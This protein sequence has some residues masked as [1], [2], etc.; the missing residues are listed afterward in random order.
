MESCRIGCGSGFWGDSAEGARQLVRAGCDFLVF[1]YLAE[2][3]MA[4]LA[5]NRRRDSTTGFVPD[6]ID[7]VFVPHARAIADQNIRVVAN[8]GGM[9]VEACRE[10]LQKVLQSQGVALKIATVSG[11]DLMPQ[12]SALARGGMALPEKLLSFNA[13]LGAAEIAGALTAGADIVIVGRCV[14]SALVLGPLVHK[15]D[16]SWSDYDLLSQGS[17]AGHL[18][19]CGVQVTG[20]ILTDWESSHGWENMGYPI[21]EC[22]ADGSFVVSKPVGTGGLVSRETVCEQ[23]VYEVGD[24]GCYRLPDVTCDWRNVEIEEVG[25]DRV[26]VSGARG[27]ALPRT[28]KASAVSHDG[29]KVSGEITIAGRNAAAKARKTALAIL[30]RTA[31]LMKERGFSDYDE[32]SVEILGA[33]ALFGSYARDQDWREVVLKVAARHRKGDALEIFS[34][35]FLTSATS[36]AQGITG[37]AAGRPKVRPVFRHHSVFVDRALVSTTVR[38]DGEIIGTEVVQ[39]AYAPDTSEPEVR[40]STTPQSVPPTTTTVPLISLAFGRSGDK[41]DDVNI[42][43]IARRVEYLPYIAAALTE[44]AV[45]ERFRH[46]VFG[47]V[48]RFDWPALPGFNF[49]LESALGGGGA[50]SLRKDPQGKT[51]AQILMECPI[52]VPPA[53]RD[54]VEGRPAATSGGSH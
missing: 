38:V 44:Q 45:Q 22:F 52:A 6:F 29:Y 41:G 20:G 30:A 14:D 18:L 26:R 25:V 53:L 39:G 34:R 21:A 5:A 47:R 32:T 35:E 43:I 12:A 50:A 15:F 54:L 1:D 36:M 3:T 40:V 28:L 16:W 33:E 9:N 10:A 48:R 31:S 13:Y 24:P 46:L 19:E 51:Y 27:H 49:V 23:L 7:H 17:L 11:D 2:T 37:F 42:G 4:I 8:A